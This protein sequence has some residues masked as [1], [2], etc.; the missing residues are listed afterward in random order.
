LNTINLRTTE[1]IENLVGVII[2]GEE[3]ELG[4]INPIKYKLVL[5]GGRFE[6]FNPKLINAD[7]AKIILS[8]QDN[9]DKL[10]KELEEKYSI[11]IDEDI[12]KL[13]FTMEKGSGIIETLLESSGVIKKME[14]KHLMYVL[15]VAIIGFSGNEAY[16][17]YIEHLNKGI[18][19]N[20][21]IELITLEKE[22]RNAE[23]ESSEQRYDELME[24]TKGIAYN[25]TLQDAVN[26]P[27]RDTLSVLK[28]DEYI[29]ASKDNIITTSDKAKYN[30]K[31]P[32][33]EDIEEVLTETHRIETYNFLKEGKLFK[34]EGISKAAISE[35]LD[36]AKRI[37]LMQKADLQ[38]S[39]KVK[40]KF[41]KDT[42]TKKTKKI[43]IMDYLTN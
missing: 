43:Y 1:D 6:D 18:E 35:T 14:S 24:L 12:K 38:E 37:A 26:K 33:L 29:K 40:L 20:R 16:S 23:R 2:R 10:L 11:V 36:G 28:D 25:K 34:F 31:K 3:F 4:E 9:Y 5:D 22:D 19:A 21:D 15:I 13:T 8:I 17:T 42:S 41:I 27:K 30:Y 7:I 32:L 39:V